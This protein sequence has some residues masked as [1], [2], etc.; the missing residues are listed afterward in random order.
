LAWIRENWEEVRQKEKE[1]TSFM[2]QKRE[3][4]KA[5]QGS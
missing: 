4:L 1:R 3:R 2:K 5:E